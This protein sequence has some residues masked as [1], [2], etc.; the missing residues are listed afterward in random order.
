VSEVNLD[1]RAFFKEVAG[2]VQD[3]GVEFNQALTKLNDKLNEIKVAQARIEERL[4][5]IE[6]L[7]NG[8][9]TEVTHLKGDVKRLN[10]NRGKV[11]TAAISAGCSVIATITILAIRGGLKP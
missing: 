8:L 7:V 10:E 6:K 4:K 2:L 1:I 11:M 9:P 3:Q 5:T